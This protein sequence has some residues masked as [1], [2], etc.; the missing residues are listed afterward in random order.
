MDIETRDCP[1][2]GIKIVG[3]KNLEESLKKIKNIVDA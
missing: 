2:C 3:G 1:E